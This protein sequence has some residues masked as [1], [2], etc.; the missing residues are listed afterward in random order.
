MGLSFF[1]GANMT[2]PHA[3]HNDHAL[4]LKLLAVAMQ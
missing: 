3:L 4:G 2:T 1:D